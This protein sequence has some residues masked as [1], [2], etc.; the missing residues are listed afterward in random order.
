M[1]LKKYGDK[2]QVHG[3][4]GLHRFARIFLQKRKSVFARVI[5]VIRVQKFLGDS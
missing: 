1:Q 5:R 4:D 3:F 2:N